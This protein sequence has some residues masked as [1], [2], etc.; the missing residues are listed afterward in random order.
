M[1]R[2]F[3]QV[4]VE[5]GQ[6]MAT[7]GPVVDRALSGLCACLHADWISALWIESTT[8]TS[9][10]VI[11]D[12]CRHIVDDYDEERVLAAWGNGQAD[13]SA[14]PGHPGSMVHEFADERAV[15]VLEGMLGRVVVAEQHA[16]LE[17]LGLTEYPGSM[18][19]VLY[20][21]HRGRDRAR[22]LIRVGRSVGRRAFADADRLLLEA[23]LGCLPI[24]DP[25]SQ[26]EE[27]KV[28]RVD[29]RLVAQLTKRQRQTLRYL[30]EGDSEKRV[31]ERLGISPHTVHNYVKRLYR[32]FDV[33]S[34][35]ALLARFIHESTELL[36][37]PSEVGDG[38]AVV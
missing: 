5:V 1:W 20:G 32:L 10:Y 8:H 2:T 3:G 35:A 4:C 14:H 11:K 31:A 12:R 25:E 15:E 6:L 24:F 34:R 36:R 29:P 38:V 22:V 23:A 17:H 7:G 26:W 28:Q 37:D 27:P 16:I 21:L 9:G 19:S 33:S 18:E 13:D 30:L